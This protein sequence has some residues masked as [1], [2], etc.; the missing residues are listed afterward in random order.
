MQLRPATQRKRQQFTHFVH[1]KLMVE[2]AVQ[3][4][5]VVGSV[6]RGT[7]RDDSDIDAVVFLDPFDLYIV[8]AESI[9]READDSFHS[10][11]VEDTDLEEN[12]L[13][14]DLKRLSW[15][16]WRD[17]AHEWPEPMRAELASAWIAF[18]RNGKITSLVADRARYTD[19]ARL[20]RLDEAVGRLEQLLADWR[21]EQVWETLGPSIAHDRLHA[22][23][24]YVVQMLF[25][26]NRTWQTWRDREMTVLL[27]LPWLPKDFN[28]HVLIALNAPSHDHAGYCARVKTLRYLFDEILN[29]LIVDGVYGNDP[30]IEAFIRNHEEPGRA[31][32]ME[33]WN[34]KHS[35]RGSI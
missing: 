8:P 20:A 11:M 13:Q 3:G 21:P 25:A 29:R 14:L 22:A 12:G 7:A 31:W 10:I 18:D 9:W 34:E 26:Y 2:P 24:A 30:I 35:E 33:L 4:V 23:Y 6:A 32:N 5:L 17:P 19:E 15:Q 28:D 1:R 16:L 27:Q